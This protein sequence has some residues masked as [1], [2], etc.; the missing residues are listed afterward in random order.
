MAPVCY[1]SSCK[2]FSP[3]SLLRTSV[4]VIGG[5]LW[6]STPSLCH[7]V[8]VVFFWSYAWWSL[9][10][11]DEVLYCWGLGSSAFHYLFRRLRAI[12]LASALPSSLARLRFP[13]DCPPLLRVVPFLGPPCCR[14]RDFAAAIHIYVE[15]WIVTVL[16]TVAWF[17]RPWI[18]SK[19]RQT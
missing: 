15:V 14:R 19:N 17:L 12:C 10:P 13:I 6:L 2:T 18:R 5:A 3:H 9:A 1:T 4:I 8:F 7:R 16:L 11:S